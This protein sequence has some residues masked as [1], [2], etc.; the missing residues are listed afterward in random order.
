LAAS[1]GP[2][3]RAQAGRVVRLLDFDG[4]IVDDQSDF[5]AWRSYWTLVRVDELHTM[6]QSIPAVEGAPPTVEISYRDYLRNRPLFA[7][8]NVFNSLERV[9]LEEDPIFRGR[10]REFVPG[11]YQVD[12]AL[13]FKRYRPGTRGQNYILRDWEHAENRARIMNERSGGKPHYDWRGPAFALF[14][15]GMSDPATVGDTKVFS[16]RWHTPDETQEL[17]D[18][19]AK[20]GAIPFSRGVNSRGDATTI[21]WHSLSSPEARLFSSDSRQLAARKAQV[22]QDEATALLHA[23]YDGRPSPHTLI[24]AEDDPRNV[25]AIAA[26]MLE[27]STSGGFSYNVKFVFFNVSSDADFKFAK[28]P[29]RFAVF[30]R[31]RARSATEAEILSW[32]TP[33]PAA[34]AAREFASAR[35]RE[36]AAAASAAAAKLE[37]LAC[38][39]VFQAIGEGK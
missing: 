1:L 39:G 3:S 25:D 31:G 15:A 35:L 22:V 8:Q 6:M 32:T 2:L 33:A 7:R 10:P 21:K 14:F 27:L 12:P 11:W 13:T 9:R 37:P 23:P 30:E 24:A 5:S 18:A 19:W 16:A 36:P 38:R 29:F 34:A 4:T 26:K 20:A 28:Y 17:M